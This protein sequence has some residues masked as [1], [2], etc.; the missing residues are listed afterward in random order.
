VTAPVAPPLTETLWRVAYPEHCAWC[1]V[2]LDMGRRHF[3]GDCDGKLSRIGTFSCRRCGSQVAPHSVTQRGCAA[4]RGLPFQF[5]RAVAPFRYEGR[6]R[7]LILLF[8]LG[9]RAELAYVLGP[10]LCDYLAEGGL[11]QDVDLIVPVPLH[12][13]RRVQRGFNQARLLALE[14]G[15]R[16]GVP[17]APRALR[18]L[19][20]TLT[21]TALTSLNR[22]ANVRDAFAVRATKAGHGI[23][24][25]AVARARGAI[26]LLGRRI[27]LVDDV[28]TTGATVNECARVLRR[29]GAD[30][31]LVAVLARANGRLSRPAPPRR[32][33]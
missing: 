33:R 13:R 15:T 23:L 6:I 28:M 12:W 11:S 20:Y 8:K 32:K 19:R 10:L 31:V 29:A 14:I 24:R 3:C 17:V 7:D 21:Q 30:R 5:E 25:Q 16:F 18:R 26:D 27:L 22:R 9:R 4:C 2:V 1:G